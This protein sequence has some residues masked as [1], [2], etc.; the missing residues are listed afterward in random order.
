MTHPQSTPHTGGQTVRRFFR[1]PLPAG[2]FVVLLLLVLSAVV[3][4]LLAPAGAATAQDGLPFQAPFGNAGPLGTDSLGRDVLMRMLGGTEVAMLTAFIVLAVSM[5]IGVPLGVIAGYLGGRTDQIIMRVTDGVMSFP[6][7]ILAMAAV[8]VI[9][10]GLVNAMIII[11][12]IFAPRF[13]RLAR[14]S[15]LSVRQQGYVEAA[16]VAGLPTGR[17]MRRHV[18]ANIR[19]PLLV[20]MALTSGNAIAAEAALSFLGLGVQAPDPSWGN[21]L[22]DGYRGIYLSPWLVVWPSLAIGLTVLAFTVIGDGLREAVGIESRS[23]R[24]PRKLRD[25]LQLGSPIEHPEPSVEPIRADADRG[26]FGERVVLEVE[27]LKVE[28]LGDQGWLPI[29][30]DVDL[31]LEAGRVLGL[32]GESGSGKSM[33]GQALMG[34]VPPDMGR[35]SS[36]RLLLDGR[37]ISALSAR[38]MAD[39][40]GNDIAMVFQDPMSSLN[41]SFKVGEQIAETVRRHTR[42]SR[43]AA[44]AKAVEMLRL[45]HVPS[46]ERVAAAYPHELSGGMRQRCVIAMALSCDPKVLIADEPTTALDVTIQAQILELIKEKSRELDMAVLFI[47]H[48]LGVVADICDRV[49]VMYAGQI[50]E[51]GPV[52]E[53]F[54]RPAHP[55]TRA[56]HDAT[57]RLDTGAPAIAALRGGPPSFG[58]L[59]HGCSFAPRCAFALEA[60]TSRPIPLER[61]GVGIVRCIR[62]DQLNL[63]PPGRELL[64]G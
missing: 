15:T 62:H 52:G 1:L 6:A 64:H 58:D 17:I 40:R 43:R 48:D 35:V 26:S 4:R 28:V 5:G 49:S 23:R 44:R 11:G 9:G 13:A 25:E 32:V 14:A 7:I 24:R 54:A 36:R 27:A 19:G 56:L 37:D 39:L 51:S 33:T 3:F 60:C 42:V 47:T 30:R 8:A 57:P 12:F 41:P 22:S 29:V 55:Y 21:I 38:Q 46:P 63:T 31:R 2:G 50:V 45:V 18:L 59:S 10:P 16:I 20:E 34:I 61:D 53:I